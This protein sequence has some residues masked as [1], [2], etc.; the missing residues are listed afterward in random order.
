MTDEDVTPVTRNVRRVPE[1]AKLLTDL[2]VSAAMIYYVTHPECIDTLKDHAKEW[3]G[4]L[5]HQVSV[6]AAQQ[7]IRSL[8]ETDEMFE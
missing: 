6:W 3:W 5:V 2:L 4:K 7:D 1:E 8:P